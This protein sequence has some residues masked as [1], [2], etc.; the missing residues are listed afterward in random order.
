MPPHEKY[1]GW[2]VTRTA[3]NLPFKRCNSE[4]V[5][6]D[7]CREYSFLPCIHGCGVEVRILTDNLEKHKNGRI[8]DHLQTCVK[9]DDSARPTKKPRNAVAISLLRRLDDG[10]PI[11]NSAHQALLSRLQGRFQWSEE[12]ASTPPTNK[13]KPS[14]E[15]NQDTSTSVIYK[16]ILIPEDRAV[17]TGKTRHEKTRLTG[18][19]SRS[20]KCRLVRNAFRKHGRW[21]FRLEVQLRCAHADADANESLMIVKNKTMFPEG[22]NLRHGA[23]AGAEE[24]EGL[25]TAMTRSCTGV[26]PFQGMGDEMLAE[27]EACADLADILHEDTV[28]P[29]EEA[30]S[31]L[32]EMIRDV[33]PDRQSPDKT[34]TPDQVTA[35]LNAVRNV[36]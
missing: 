36:V 1:P 11:E 6:E 2:V 7:G 26:M 9:L 29:G 17:Y 16:L 18:H 3:R 22:Y 5:G 19:A 21:A 34:Y 25:S 35:M 33:H 31:L 30:D 24:E 14:K 8:E 23:S 13:P 12:S 28:S 4:K 20:S 32:R 15:S 27:S 10:V